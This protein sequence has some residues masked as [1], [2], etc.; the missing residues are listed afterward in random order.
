MVLRVGFADLTTRLD[1]DAERR[2]VGGRHEAD[3][4]DVA[5]T[6]QK[7]VL[8]DGHRPDAAPHLPAERD[9]AAVRR[10]DDAGQAAHFRQHARVERFA[11]RHLSVLR[12][13]ETGCERQHAIRFESGID[14]LDG[15]QRANQQSRRDQEDD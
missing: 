10:V 9:I 13:H 4:R 2:K 14:R 8:I 1:R 6:G 11:R 12:H 5:S 15:P 3:E 7:R